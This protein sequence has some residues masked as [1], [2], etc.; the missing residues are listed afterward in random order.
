MW[1]FR[2]LA[3]LCWFSFVILVDGKKVPNFRRGFLARDV[4]K[5]GGRTLFGQT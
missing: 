1:V 2:R 3:V 5:A 4:E